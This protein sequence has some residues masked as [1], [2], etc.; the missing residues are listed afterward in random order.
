MGAMHWQRGQ[1][2]VS[3]PDKIATFSNQTRRVNSDHIYG[4]LQLEV[5]VCMANIA[6]SAGNAWQTQI[7]EQTPCNLI[8]RQIVGYVS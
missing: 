6:K 4:Q 7:G 8:R 2:I 3:A 5:T 1:L